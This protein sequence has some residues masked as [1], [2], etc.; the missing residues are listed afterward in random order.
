MLRQQTAVWLGALSE[1]M[2][3]PLGRKLQVSDAAW[4][5]LA[6]SSYWQGH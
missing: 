5:R 4:P 6:T 3:S 2:T 1:L